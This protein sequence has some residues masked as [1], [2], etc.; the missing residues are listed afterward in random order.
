MR[1]ID[2]SRG[3]DPVIAFTDIRRDLVMFR[4]DGKTY[5]FPTASLPFTLKDMIFKGRRTMTADKAL[6][7]KHGQ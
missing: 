3:D 4:I 1:Q 6:V 7:L 2:I 5:E